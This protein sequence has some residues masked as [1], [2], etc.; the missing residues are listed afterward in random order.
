MK[1]KIFI[2]FLEHLIYPL[3]KDLLGRILKEA[4]HK[5]LA[6]VKKLFNKWKTKEENSAKNDEEKNIITKRW[7]DRIRDFEK[8]EDT[9]D[10]TVD[11][12]IRDAILNSKG[13]IS[14]FKKEIELL[15]PDGK[16]DQ[17]D[18]TAS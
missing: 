2:M 16:S 1:N 13:R 7:D 11:G 10:E 15:N 12:I 14:D 6:L 8:M 5:L 17:K 4:A 3:L 18:V 9:I